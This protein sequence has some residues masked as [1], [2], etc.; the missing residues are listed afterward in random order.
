M[1]FTDKWGRDCWKPNT[2]AFEMVENEFSVSG[3]ECV[4]IADNPKKD[5]VGPNKMGWDSIYVRRRNGEYSSEAFPQ[6]GKP[7]KSIRS[8]FEL[9]T[10]LN[11]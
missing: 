1:Y 11:V 8:L 5:F 10:V 2:C 9:I 7:K 3:R 6:G 4:Y